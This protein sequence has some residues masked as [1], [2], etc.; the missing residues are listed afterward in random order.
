MSRYD[1]SFAPAYSLSRF[2]A[3]LGLAAAVLTISAVVV[4]TSRANSDERSE[5]SRAAAAKVLRAASSYLDDAGLG[6]PTISSLKRDHLLDKDTPLS[7]AWG[8]RFRILCSGGVSVQ[9][10]GPDGKL[11]TQDDV[12]Q[13]RAES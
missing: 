6:C 2:E 4:A 3:K 1:K 9:S 7:D 12:R 8:Q 11:N 10:A 13:Q 5:T